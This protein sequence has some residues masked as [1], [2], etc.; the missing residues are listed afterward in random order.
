MIFL[1]KSFS[2]SIQVEILFFLIHFIISI[3][4]RIEIFGGNGDLR[5]FIIYLLTKEMKERK[6]KSDYKKKIVTVYFRSPFRQVLRKKKKK[7]EKKKIEIEIEIMH[8]SILK[9]TESGK[10]YC[11]M[12]IFFLSRGCFRFLFQTQ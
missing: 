2:M 8:K 1:F 5:R 9:E 3:R 4:D 12:W 10:I 6:K 7:T 11:F